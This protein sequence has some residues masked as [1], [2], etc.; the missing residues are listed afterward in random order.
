M[1]ILRILMGLIALAFLNAM[2]LRL[3]SFW[4]VVLYFCAVFT[5]IQGGVQITRRLR[6]Y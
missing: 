2:E 4:G 5:L 6:G 1:A 3:F